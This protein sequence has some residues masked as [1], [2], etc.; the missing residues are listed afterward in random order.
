MVSAALSALN[1]S[2]S[3]AT[4][5]ANDYELIA[6]IV[7]RPSLSR[8]AKSSGWGIFSY[9]GSPSV[10]VLLINKF[11]NSEEADI[12]AG[13]A[14]AMMTI[15]AK[16]DVAWLITYLD[17]PSEDV[18]QAAESAI[19]KISGVRLYEAYPKLSERIA[20]RKEWWAQH[21]NDVEYQ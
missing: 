2:G 6:D 9:A 11:R 17:D 12:R 16:A 8:N 1:V 14:R 10:R 15:G 20:K 21:R 5:T 4:L 19:W 18:E 7:T 13:L 3:S